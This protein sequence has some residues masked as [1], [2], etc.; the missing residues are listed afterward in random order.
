M[1]AVVSGPRSRSRKANPGRALPLT[2]IAAVL[3]AFTVPLPVD[4]PVL[5]LT[6]AQATALI[7]VATFAAEV[8]A[9][10]RLPLPA[11]GS[12]GMLLGLVLLGCAA[13]A[14]AGFA[15]MI[16]AIDR[17]AAFSYGLRF[18]LGAGVVLALM[19][20]HRDAIT[21]HRTV[22]ALLGGGLLAVGLAAAGYAWPALGESTIGVGR[23]AEGFFDHPNQLGMILSALAPIALARAFAFP[24][25]IRSWLASAALVYGVLLTASMANTLLIVVG[26][27]ILLFA[28]FSARFS[29][30]R[31]AAGLVALVTVVGVLLAFGP[32]LV[33]SVSPR[34]A[35]L[36]GIFAGGSFDETLPSVLDRLRLYGDALDEIRAA[37]LLGV[38]GDNATHYLANPSGRPVFHAH[39][40]LL[41]TTLGTGLVGLVAFL[42]LVVGWLALSVRML[43]TRVGVEPVIVPLAKGLGAALLIFFL[44]NQSSDSL[45]G[46][47]VYLLWLLLGLG[48]ALQRH[49][50]PHERTFEP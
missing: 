1:T 29:L 8:V 22:R 34:V 48:L 35:S 6:L 45:G 17:G 36:V 49:A 18:V 13:T 31:F 32:T 14:T 30:A 3:H 46:T 40:V 9:R 21:V 10:R 41:N 19:A 4:L 26:A 42:P 38:G 28:A 37:P 33:D 25:R 50:T 20:S 47:V 5:P 16:P 23:R 15:S 2:K 39:N 24:R 27:L 7:L 43:S 11:A 12:M 44:S